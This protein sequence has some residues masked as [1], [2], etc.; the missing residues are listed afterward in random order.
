VLVSGWLSSIGYGCVPEPLVDKQTIELGHGC[1][2][3]LTVLHRAVN[4]LN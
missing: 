2:D 3:A 4:P 1:I